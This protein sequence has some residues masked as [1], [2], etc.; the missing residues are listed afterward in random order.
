[1]RIQPIH[2]PKER[3][4]TPEAPV[5]EAERTSLR[6]LLGELAWP[7]HEGFP[8]YCYDVSDMQQRVNEATV[9]SLVRAN[10]VLKRMS[11]R[12]KE[13]AL[14][15]PRGDGTGRLVVGLM[16]DASFARQPRG[17]S[18]QGYVLM[19]A[20]RRLVFESSAPVAC[21]FWQ[22]T[23]IKRVVRST[24]AAE[25]AATATG[26]D[27]AILLRILLSRLLSS[28]TAAASASRRDWRE[29]IK[30]VPQ[31]SWTDCRSLCEMLGKDT[32]TSSEKRVVLDIYDVKQYL[33][34]DDFEWL[35]TTLM[36]ADPLT[37]HFGD[38][39]ANALR[40]LLATG[41]LTLPPGQA[42]AACPAG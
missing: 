5:T 29:E 31:I 15:F 12:S 7:A 13:V 14:R 4:R 18:Q 27:M 17:G 38:R 23:R 35:P 22:S 21:V 8:E 2:V 39:D 20:D 28:T 3:R 26:Y 40:D 34:E 33:A 37:K 30:E 24:L 1:L 42:E 6:S 32:P 10:S 16:T 19:L 9:S 11:A 25:A 36:V 41:V